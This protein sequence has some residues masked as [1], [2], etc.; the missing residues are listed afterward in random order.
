MIISEMYLLTKQESKPANNI[1]TLLGKP[2]CNVL[3]V[4]TGSKKMKNNYRE[5]EFI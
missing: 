2:G 3:L 1:E 5:S 4:Y